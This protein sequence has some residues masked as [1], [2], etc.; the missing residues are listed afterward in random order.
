MNGK[1]AEVYALRMMLLL[2]PGISQRSEQIFLIVDNETHY[3]LLVVCLLGE[4][5]LLA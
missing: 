5:I 4:M 1:V 2:A 3:Q